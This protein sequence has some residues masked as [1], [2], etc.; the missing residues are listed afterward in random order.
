MEDLSKK[1]N[2]N[3]HLDAIANF[4]KVSRGYESAF[5]RFPCCIGKVFEN[6]KIALRRYEKYLQ[7]IRTLG[8]DNKFEEVILKYGQMYSERA[9]KSIEQVYSASYIQLIKRSMKN[10]ELCLGN[11]SIKNIACRDNNQI[12]VVSFE[13]CC[14]NMV[15]M[16]GVCYLIKYKKKGNSFIEKGIKLYCNKEELDENSYRFMN[17]LI[18]YPYMV[19][20]CCLRYKENPSK[21]NLDDYICSLSKAA[22]KEGD[23]IDF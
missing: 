5:C 6:Y 20:R 18:T 22:Q 9:Q 15:E 8:P 10:H 19:I 1:D 11:T 23:S 12:E 16:D 13:K 2:L 7:E 4:H 21:K 14:V 17:A 3:T